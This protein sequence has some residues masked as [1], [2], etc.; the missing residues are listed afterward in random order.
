MHHTTRLFLG[1]LSALI[2]LTIATPRSAQAVEGT[3]LLGLGKPT[4][5]DTDRFNWGPSVAGSVGG[6]VAERLS[7]HGQLQLSALD[8]RASNESGQ[9]FQIAFVPLIHLL[10]QR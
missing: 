5:G 1:S 8:T 2:A 3:V 4:N 10:G 9:Y 7:L 6:R